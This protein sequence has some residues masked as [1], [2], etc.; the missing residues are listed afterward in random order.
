[1]PEGI[2]SPLPSQRAL[3]DLVTDVLREMITE[4]KFQ[5]GEHLRESHL[6]EALQVSRGP[7]RQAFARL[8]EE[9]HVELRRHRGAFVSTLTKA[10]IEE[11][12]TLRGAIERLAASRACARMQG[13]GFA[14]MDAVLE[15]MRNVHTRPDPEDAAQLDLRFHDIIYAYCGHSRV[16]RV[17]ASIRGQVT[18]FLRARNASFPD[19]LEVGHVEHLELR[20]ALA[21]GDPQAAQDAI[22]KHISGAYERL[23]RLN[24]PDRDPSPA[25][26]RTS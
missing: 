12:H 13:E 10:D 20:D 6:A 25:E 4:G 19:F 26:D 17:W 15:Q 9:G 21:L 23:K 7:I 3:G 22:D 18:V 24:L 2:V 11:V 8:E 1:M 16:Q 14:E 5:P